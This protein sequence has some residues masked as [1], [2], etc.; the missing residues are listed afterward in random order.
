MG[1]TLTWMVLGTYPFWLNYP[2]L[3]QITLFVGL[4]LLVFLFFF[5]IL[6]LDQRLLEK[7]KNIIQIGKITL[8]AICFSLL[9]T[10]FLRHELPISFSFPYKTEKVNI[11]QEKNFSSALDC[12]TQDSFE[13]S[14]RPGKLLLHPFVLN[15]VSC[16]SNEQVTKRITQYSFFPNR[17]T[18]K[19]N[20]NFVGNPEN[21]N[22]RII[23][24]NSQNLIIILIRQQK[25][26]SR[27]I[28][29]LDQ[30][31]VYYLSY[32]IDLGIIFLILVLLFGSA[33]SL[34]IL[35]YHMVLDTYHMVL[36][37]MS[38]GIARFITDLIIFSIKRSRLFWLILLCCILILLSF[39]SKSPIHGL[40]SFLSTLSIILSTI[41][42][43]SLFR[44]N[45]WITYIIG[46]C[47]VLFTNI[48][49][50]TQI[51]GIIGELSHSITLVILHI[52]IL[53]IVFLFYWRVRPSRLVPEFRFSGEKET[54][55]HIESFFIN[56][57]EIVWLIVTTA[58][59][60]LIILILILLLP[61]NIDDILTTYLFRAGFWNQQ[62]SFK[63]WAASEY[64]L[65]QIVYPLNGQLPLAWVIKL[66][67]NDKLAGFLQYMSIPVGIAGIYGLSKTLGASRKQALLAGLIFLGLPEVV[68]ISST[69]LTDLL[70][71]N[72]FVACV[73][74][75]I[76]GIQEND[77][78]AIVFSALTLG[79]ILGIKQTV[80][81]VLPGLGLMVL[82]ILLCGRKKVYKPLL[83]WILLS[84]LSFLIF[85]SFI[86]FKNYSQFGNPLG[87]S[88]LTQYF[89][90]DADTSAKPAFLISGL[91]NYLSLLLRSFFDNLP[92][93]IM[94]FVW[95]I[96]LSI[97]PN[98]PLM[99]SFL[100]ANLYDYSVAWSS[101]IG[102]LIFVATF[103]YGVFYSIKHKKWI[104]FGVLIS[105]L[106]YTT[107]LM[108]IRKFTI[109]SSRYL[110][111]V[112]ALLVPMIFLLTS[113][114]W[115]RHL[116]VINS[117]LMMIVT[118][119]FDGAKPLVGQNAIWGKT[120]NELRSLQFD[121]GLP[122]FNAI[123]EYLPSDT[124][125]GILLPKKFPQ[126]YLFGQDYS[127]RVIPLDL[128]Y[129]S[130][131]FTQLTDS[132]IEFLLVDNL[133]I[134]EGF[135][136]PE[137]LSVVCNDPELGFIIYQV[138]T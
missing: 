103:F 99:R 75:M 61:S 118:L 24:P 39:F 90:H 74:L 96:V 6:L 97:N 32:G 58:I 131:T 5:L 130:V 134:E 30:G 138:P 29:L 33:L 42:L 59:C 91:Q 45:N 21:G 95:K 40:Y 26:Y 31:T 104:M 125:I 87:P 9:G 46:F 23:P 19:A 116:L 128:R 15:E 113:K 12:S 85:S 56:N 105:I 102:M 8:F 67:G 81:F 7:H 43:L 37:K 52:T 137:N 36:K 84:L 3:L 110:L 41:F 50:V 49:L 76:R 115:I 120:P 2:L 38:K 98:E 11:V 71:A 79:I 127:R 28:S 83:T 60:Y 47:L 136:I 18:A 133:L 53:L 70:V 10:L 82:I 63:I 92:F 20:I 64:N 86:Y 106:S 117:I 34:A 25:D 14:I 121:N 107:I 72:F 119:L 78:S 35:T 114:K 109:A 16:T 51:T 1:A 77:L 129:G 44:I 122:I 111:I 88:E 62:G 13:L 65:P 68:I 22:V 27:T 4:F 69:A 93:P 124:T 108:F 73:Y 94:Q 55:L 112:V 101:Q 54:T 123:D 17:L 132:G 135:I 80:F 126:S 100:P 57:P 89:T 48:I 66:F